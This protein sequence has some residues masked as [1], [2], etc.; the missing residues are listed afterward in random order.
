METLPS[1][2][3]GNLDFAEERRSLIGMEA[4]LPLADEPLK[5]STFYL[6]PPIH[7]LTRMVCSAVYGLYSSM[8]PATCVKAGLFVIPLL[9]TRENAK[10]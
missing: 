7:L 10:A 1:K 4:F 8:L 3:D 6:T 2:E 9:S 5:G